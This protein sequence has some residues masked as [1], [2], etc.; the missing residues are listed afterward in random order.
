LAFQADRPGE[1]EKFRDENR[2]QVLESF[3]VL[4]APGADDGFG[5]INRALLLR[6]PDFSGLVKSARARFKNI[7]ALC[8][9]E[10]RAFNAK[11]S[12]HVTARLSKFR[13]EAAR[14]LAEKYMQKVMVEPSAKYGIF[15][16]DAV[17]VEA[18]EGF[19]PVDD[20][21]LYAFEK[22]GGRQDLA[23]DDRF[24]RTEGNFNRIYT[25]NHLY[26]EMKPL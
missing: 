16:K 10:R 22:S 12:P 26:L 2:S 8:G 5:K 25:T 9:Q 7:K 14:P 3:E 11:P 13:S 18:S 4:E 17:H 21:F 19:A 15:E 24:K 23:R 1:F 20:F 6:A